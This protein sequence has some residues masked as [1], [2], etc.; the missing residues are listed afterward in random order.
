MGYGGYGGNMQQIMKQAQMMQ[1]K[2]QQAQ[3]ELAEA[4]V[5]G[6]AGGG[7][8]EITLKGDKTPVAV[9]IKPEA[10]DPDDIEMLEDLLLAALGDAMEQADAASGE[11]R[12]SRRR[13]VLSIRETLPE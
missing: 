12:T 13:D 6:K 7:I 5:V 9:S 8:V 1:K 4:E 2:L 3:A 11:A 10:V